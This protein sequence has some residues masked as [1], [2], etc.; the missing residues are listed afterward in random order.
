MNSLI[1]YQNDKYLEEQ[2]QTHNPI[3]SLH[4]IG[5]G[6][7]KISQ[8]LNKKNIKTSK[9]NTWKNTKVYSVLK[10]FTERQKRLELINRVYEPVWGKIYLKTVKLEN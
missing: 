4:E 3:K 5:M 2:E 6:Y 1:H 7:R 8:I 9:E 10:R